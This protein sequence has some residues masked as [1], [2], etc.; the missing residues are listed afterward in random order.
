MEHIEKIIYSRYFLID[1][2]DPSFI[3]LLSYLFKSLRLIFLNRLN[4]LPEALSLIYKSNFS[5]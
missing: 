1:A 4:L 2:Y 5:M 3:N